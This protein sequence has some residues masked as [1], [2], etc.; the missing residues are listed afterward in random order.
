MVVKK[1]CNL[2]I[3]LLGFL[4]L[5]RAEQC[6]ITSP[7]PMPV[8]LTGCTYSGSLPDDSTSYLQNGLTPST[9]TQAFSVQQGTVTDSFTLGYAT[10]GTCA[11]FDSTGKLI[12]ASDPCGIGTGGG[13]VV[14][15]ST[16]T[17]SD[18]SISSLSVSTATK[19]SRIEWA[20]GTV[21]ISSPQ[22]G[23]T[24]SSGVTVYPATATASFPF[25]FSG[26]TV[27]VS[28]ITATG[29]ITGKTLTLTDYPGMSIDGS[30]IS[31]NATQIL[32]GGRFKPIR[33]YNDG[34]VTNSIDFYDDQ[35]DSDR[36]YLQFLPFFRDNGDF[37]YTGIGADIQTPT[38]FPLYLTPGGNGTFP[39]TI[40]NQPI[41]STNTWS[42]SH[43][44]QRSVTN[45][46]STTFKG[47][48]IISSTILLSGSPGNSG[49]YL[50]SQG[51][52]ALAI[53]D[54]PTSGSGGTSTLAVTT[55]TTGGFGVPVSSPAAVI[56]LDQAMFQTALEGSATA[57]VTIAYSTTALTGSATITSTD[58][59]IT[60]DATGAGLTVTLPTPVGISGR[61]YDIK[62]IDSTSNA[63]T[64]TAAAGTIDGAATQVLYLQ[65]TNLE[66]IS[67]GK[68]YQIR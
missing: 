56:N 48:V 3:I 61:V 33:Y 32:S 37:T 64:V 23:G 19:V 20:D 59:F 26:S 31:F 51:Q 22:V 44:F 49:Q 43:T 35:I 8:L 54:T 9:T 5:A 63:V 14:V 15:P 39:G 53:W 2:S 68:N 6:Q 21:Q 57:F 24:S 27:A 40:P 1:L 25:G 13:G 38:G 50:K 58:S 62:K 47:A 4:G 45:T 46:S 41:A 11:E 29:S 60:A 12:S 18:V 36:K 7:L 17:W 67:D 10:P 52:N 55:G 66:V 42:G 28:S 34:V 16:F 30:G 65:Y